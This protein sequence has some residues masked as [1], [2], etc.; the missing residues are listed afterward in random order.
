MIALP[1]VGA[2]ARLRLAARGSDRRFGHEG[3]GR[4]VAGGLS[5]EA[6]P[7]I[8][9]VLNRYTATANWSRPLSARPI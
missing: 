8:T 6:A 1:L 7:R 9:E 3:Q 2:G 5:V 4:I